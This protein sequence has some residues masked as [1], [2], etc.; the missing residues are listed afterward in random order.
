M[1]R[2]ERRHVE[3]NARAACNDNESVLESCEELNNKRVPEEEERFTDSPR[4]QHLH[5]FTRSINVNSLGA[6]HLPHWLKSAAFEDAMRIVDSQSSTT[7][8]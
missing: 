6:V 5:L 2:H 7:S 3:S 4:R 8:F 1:R